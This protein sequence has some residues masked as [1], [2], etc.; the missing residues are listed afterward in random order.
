VAAGASERRDPARNE[1]LCVVAERLGN[2]LAICR[3]SYVHPGLM[4]AFLDGAL[5]PAQRQRRAGLSAEECDLVAVLDS[6]S[7]QRVAA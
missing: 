5:A 4:A 6:L 1:A 3:K 7:R 2:T